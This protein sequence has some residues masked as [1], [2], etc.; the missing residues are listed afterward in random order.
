LY[1]K[2]SVKTFRLVV[3]ASSNAIG[4]TYDDLF[5]FTSTPLPTIDFG[6]FKKDYLWDGMPFFLLDR[7]GYFPKYGQGN[8][9]AMVYYLS[10]VPHIVGYLQSKEI[11]SIYF[12]NTPHLSI[13]WLFAKCA[14]YCGIEVIVS[15]RHILPWRYSLTKGFDRFRELIDFSIDTDELVAD[16]LE[17]KHVDEFIQLN[18]K[19]YEHALPIYEKKRMG[20]GSL[21]F[22]N[23]IKQWREWVYNPYHYYKKYQAYKTYL[24]IAKIGDLS[25]RFIT[26]F[27]HY[28]PERTTLPE[29][30]GFQNQLLA[31]MELRESLPDDVFIYVKEHPSMFTNIWHPKVRNEGFY[32][33]LSEL[34]NVVLVALK[35]NTFDLIDN[36]LAVATITG[37]VG[38]QAYIRKKPVIF[39]GLSMFKARGVHVYSDFKNLKLFV[40]QLLDYDIIIEN[41][42]LNLYQTLKGSITGLPSD[43][44]DNL[45]Y[46]SY[47]NYEEEAHF[48]L[49]S[50]YFQEKLIGCN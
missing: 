32:H 46:Y 2:N 21:Q 10:R 18:S 17:I 13:E 8:H 48:K 9:N 24:S 19:D 43:K 15:Q 11:K 16:T 23:P 34:P 27:L 12:R 33:L 7:D 1:K 35:Q 25:K 30:Y 41:V 45:D 20:K 50:F 6:L 40:S 39:F 29:G 36:A 4:I 5:N 42:R 44:S 49:L 14:N 38:V 28:Q 22:L 31:V 47:V 37:T 26:F 3:A